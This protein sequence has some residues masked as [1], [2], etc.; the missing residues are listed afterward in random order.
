M[1]QCLTLISGQQNQALD[2]ARKKLNAVFIQLGLNSNTAVNEMRKFIARC[3]QDSI[4]LV[5]SAI[6]DLKP[7]VTATN[8]LSIVQ[9]NVSAISVPRIISAHLCAIY[10]KRQLFLASD[11]LHQWTTTSVMASNEISEHV[12]S[13]T[14][15]DWIHAHEDFN[16]SKRLIPETVCGRYSTVNCDCD[17]NSITV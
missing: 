10:F 15:I 3:K 4:K 1:A 13:E 16:D 7:L 8:T 5:I 9:H 6:V 14:P 12:V 11:I 17:C 2:M